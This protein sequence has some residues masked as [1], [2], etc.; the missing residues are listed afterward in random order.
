MTKLYTRIIQHERKIQY[1]A[2]NSHN[3]EPGKLQ[4]N[5]YWIK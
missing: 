3:N 4:L 5:F 2:F 1:P